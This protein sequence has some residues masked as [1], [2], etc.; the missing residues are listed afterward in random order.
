MHRICL[1]HLEIAIKVSV[2]YMLAI[3]DCSDVVAG[4]ESGLGHGL[5]QHSTHSIHSTLGNGLIDT[6]SLQQA[7]PVRLTGQLN[8]WHASI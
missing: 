3:V 1:I 8:M 7:L 4:S 5:A 2:L 6:S